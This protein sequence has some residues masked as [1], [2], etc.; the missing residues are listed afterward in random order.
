LQAK[1]LRV[2]DHGEVLPVGASRPQR[3]D[4]RVVAATNRDLHADVE[5][6]R[7]RADL[8]ARIAQWRITLDPLRVR[9]DDI[10]LIARALLAADP[11]SPPLSAN[12]AEALLL[13]RW[14]FNVRELASTV[15]SAMVAA[16]GTDAI[17]RAHLP[18]ELRADAPPV[19]RE[20]SDDAILPAS[21]QP[22]TGR[23]LAQLARAMN[24]NVAEMARHMGTSRVQIYRMLRRE[25][26]AVHRYR[27]AEVDP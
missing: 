5:A 10:L 21:G 12:A 9:R 26:I 15:R 19:R 4:L 17:E 11:A 7:F 23:E 20:E 16:S 1:L 3:V 2:L 8:Y 22:L 25:K 14:R 27:G 24:G 6:E 13:H 18:S